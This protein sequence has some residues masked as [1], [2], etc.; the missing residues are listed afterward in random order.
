MSP[1][2]HTAAYQALGLVWDYDAVDVTAKQLPG[3]L[4]GLG[5]RWRGLSVTAPLKLPMLQWCDQ[6]DHLGAM[7]SAVNTV[8]VEPDGRRLGYNTDVTGLV[9]ALRQA[10]VAGADRL[11]VVGG[12]ATAASALAAGAEL[13]CGA[14]TVFMRTPTAGAPLIGVG[15]R[16]GIAVRVLSLESAAA[17]PAA[18]VLISTIPA[19]AQSAYV[20]ALVGLADTVLDVIYDPWDT[21]LIQAAEQVRRRAVHGFELLLHQAG[22]QVELMTGVATA[23][24]TRMR[25]AGLAAAGQPH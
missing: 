23:P 17:Q 6:L 19:A 1:A 5:P 25:A 2:L 12:G 3:F 16:L 8:L 10:G 15:E 21:P 24:L 20:V 9:E 4:A 18:D 22:R 14:A 11:I 7:V 13:G